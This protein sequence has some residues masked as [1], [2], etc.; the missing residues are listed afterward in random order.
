[1]PEPV[2]FT[3]IADTSAPE[4]AHLR[5]VQI[6]DQQSTPCA[7][8][9]ES[10]GLW[11]GDEYVWV[12]PVPIGGAHTLRAEFAKLQAVDV[13]ESSSV[14]ELELER[15]DGTSCVRVPLG[16][17]PPRVHWQRRIDWSIESGLRVSVP[18]S[19]V[20]RLGAGYSFDVDLG[21]WLGPL[22]LRAGVGS[23]SAACEHDCGEDRNSFLISPFRTMVDVSLLERGDFALMVG[24]GY[25]VVMVLGGGRWLL[26]GPRA[27][28]TLFYAASPRPSEGSGLRRG[29]I[30]VELAVARWYAPDSAPAFVLS[31]GLVFGLGL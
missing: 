26:H 18:L 25:D 11:V 19:P 6:A 23:G 31:T 30:G 4:G 12:R 21:Y 8:A 10:A 22:R 3:V 16:S 7:S 27:A 14:L 5:S 1:M 15:G 2:R 13:L 17:A 9:T 24:G 28:Q 20:S 29:R